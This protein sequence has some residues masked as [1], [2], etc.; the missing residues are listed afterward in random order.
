MVNGIV[1]RLW[2]IRAERVEAAALCAAGARTAK[3][4]VRAPA[5]YILAVD[6]RGYQPLR[7]GMAAAVETQERLGVTA[8]D[9]SDDVL[10][11]DVE[12]RGTGSSP[13]RAAL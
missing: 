9:W 5:A 3:S 4:L 13:S 7:T 10:H 2:S 1:A 12:R 11:C 8:A 6:S